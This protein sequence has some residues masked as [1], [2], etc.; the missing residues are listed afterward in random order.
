MGATLVFGKPYSVLPIDAC[1]NVTYILL[2][3]LQWSI[4]AILWELS[5]VF[6]CSVFP[7]HIAYV[8]QITMLQNVIIHEDSFILICISYAYIV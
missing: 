1:H 4:Y 6:I 7:H 2:L 8:F 5:H 3:V